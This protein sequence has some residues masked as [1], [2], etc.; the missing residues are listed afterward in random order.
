[1]YCFTFWRSS[2]RVVVGAWVINA[3]TVGG[4]QATG[5]DEI[6]VGFTL[7]GCWRGRDVWRKDNQRE[8]RKYQFVM[9][10][11]YSLDPLTTGP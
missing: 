2:V 1:M 5:V 9:T 11:H 6:L 8:R 7:A 3:V 10:E 4:G